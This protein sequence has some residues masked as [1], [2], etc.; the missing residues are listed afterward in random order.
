MPESCS[1]VLAGRTFSLLYTADAYFE[2]N[3]AAGEDF[4][5][6]LLSP[7]R[8]SY[9]TALSCFVIL[10]REGELTRRY[11][12]FEA[13]DIADEEELRRTL[14]PADIPV[15]KNAVIDAI[16]AGLRVSAGEKRGPRDIG[17]ENYEKKTARA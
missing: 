3:E 12:G 11:R 7:S 6:K 8:G 13:E 14:T 1:V 5:E 4:M 2:I 15:L 16:C 10:A 17:L 9:E